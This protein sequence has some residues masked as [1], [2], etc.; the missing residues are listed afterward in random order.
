MVAAVLCLSIL[1]G[2]IA[3]PVAKATVTAPYLE[4]D[5]GVLEGFASTLDDILALPAFSAPAATAS[6]ATAVEMAAGEA[7][8]YTAVTAGTAVALGASGLVAGALLTYGALQLY[9]HFNGESDAVITTSYI[10]N[11]KWRWYASGSGTYNN[12]TASGAPTGNGLW[13]L[14]FGEGC[15]EWGDPN[16]YGG[17]N[18][19][20]YYFYWPSSPSGSCGSNM[21]TE[22]QSKFTNYA[23]GSFGA[24][25]ITLTQGPG[26][27]HGAIYLTQ[28]EVDAHAGRLDVLPTPYSNQSHTYSYTGP[29]PRPAADTS[30]AR[31]QITASS[32][33]LQN[34]YNHALDPDDWAAP[35]TDYNPATGGG[36]PGGHIW[37]MPDC[38]GLSVADCESTLTDAALL[39]GKDLTFT[40]GTASTTDTTVAKDLVLA[41]E[42][43][44]ET[45]DRPSAIT[46]TKNRNDG[47]DKNCVS[48]TENPH[49]STNGDTVV[50]KANVTCN[51]TGTAALTMT[52]WKCTDSPSADAT[53]L[54]NGAWGCSLAAA[55]EKVIPVVAEVTEDPAAYCPDVGAP[56][57]EGNAY[58]IAM[59]TVSNGL[60][61][62]SPEDW[63][64]EQP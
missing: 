25:K 36:D 50:A 29:N 57:V 55:T 1:A 47:P 30:A 35:S 45:K 42:P 56:L 24:H 59:T 19:S 3:T 17:A 20:V 40:V 60:P 13:A 6:E 38:Y 39:S 61:S 15:S 41:T 37:T 12:L 9:E 7:V 53:A 54:E 27:G 31:A 33:G 21:R 8:G 43:T 51:Y 58:F 32:V 14:T 34:L 22:S 44:A 48:T 23:G 64:V 52:L 63:Y 16:Y 28:A 46:V 11:F 10:T 26:S 2:S 5:P 4:T 62:W 49:W 18:A